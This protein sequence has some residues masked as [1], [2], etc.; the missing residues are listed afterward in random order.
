M[1]APQRNE[2]IGDEDVQLTGD[3]QFVA[4]PFKFTA[5][6]TCLSLAEGLSNEP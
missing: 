5:D 3:R 1:F 2:N 4:D 6:F